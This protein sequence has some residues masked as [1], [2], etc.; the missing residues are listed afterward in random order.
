MEPE[1]ATLT[2]RRKFLVALVDLSRPPPEATRDAHARKD[3]IIIEQQALERF[4][5]KDEVEVGQA[6]RDSLQQPQAWMVS[7]ESAT[8]GVV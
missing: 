2:E 3:A 8:R 6:G 4:L 7:K 5:D 1:S